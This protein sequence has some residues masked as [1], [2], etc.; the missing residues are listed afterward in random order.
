MKMHIRTAM[1]LMLLCIAMI[2][3]SGCTSFQDGL[4]GMGLGFERFRSGLDAKSVQLDDHTVAYTERDG[5]PG[6]ETII[7]LHGFSANKSHWVR[8][9]RYLPDEYR[10]LAMDMPGHGDSTQ[11]MNTPYT[12]TDIVDRLSEA[13]D[14]IGV[15]RFHMAGNSLG[16]LVSTRYALRNPDRV[17]T[18][19]LFNAAG[20]TAPT[21]S[22]L[23]KHMEKG[24]NFLLPKTREAFDRLMDFTFCDP[25][26]IPWPGHAV[27]ARTYIDNYPFNRKMWGDIH[28]PDGELPDVSDRLGEITLP[29]F[30][31]WG[32]TDNFLHVSCVDVFEQHISDST[33]VIM[34]NC[35]HVPMMERPKE[36]A[37]HYMRF[38]RQH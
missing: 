1:G 2:P 9:V 12:V 29:V 21:P 36:T 33:S 19:G 18:L 17:L 37:G 8:F 27:L 11:D 13:I 3:I 23:E 30:I 20:V 7:L 34:D 15:E 24:D 16:G 26:F 31:L 38:L 5:E 22:E 35:G 14:R 28:E 25:P 32:D 6:G 10:V 4:Y